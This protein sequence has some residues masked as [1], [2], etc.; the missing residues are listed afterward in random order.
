MV[1]LLDSSASIREHNFNRMKNFVKD[2]VKL[3]SMENCDYRFGLSK[4]AISA[5]PE[6]YLNE[7]EDTT[8]V[9]NAVDELGYIYGNTDTAE[10]IRQ[11]REDY[12][13]KEKGDRPDARNMIVLVTDGLDNAHTIRRHA[14]AVKTKIAGIGLLPIGVNVHEKEELAKMTSWQSGPLLLQNYKSLEN[15]SSDFVDYIIKC[16]HMC[17]LNLHDIC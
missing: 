2:V 4:F 5:L 10:A 7:Y 3:L 16:K 15:Y 6:F 17:S 11:T 13:R 8:N 14:E 9:L 1:F 12:F